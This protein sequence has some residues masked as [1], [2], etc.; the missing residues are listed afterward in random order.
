MQLRS[1]LA[2][3][4]VAS[5]ALAQLS[6]T[7]PN[8]YATAE[9]NS[10]N[11][12][13]WNRFTNTALRTQLL[14]D[15]TNFTNAGI[16]YPIVIS[17]LQWRANAGTT[18]WAGGVLANCTV[19]MSTA[20]VDQNTP[21]AT[22]ASNHGPNLATVYSGPVNFIAGTGAGTGIPGPTVV[23]LT[24]TPFVYDPN[25]GD[26]VIDCDI[27]VGAGSGT[28]TQLDVQTTASLSSRVYNSTVAGSP[29]GTIN[30]SHGVVVTL[31]YTPAAGL[32]PGFTA[33]GRDVAVGSTVQFTDQSFT[34]DPAGIL[35]RNWDLNGDGV[36]D[37]SATNPSFIY[38][39]EGRYNVSLQ[40][41][42]ALHGPVTVT[43]TNYLTVG[44][45]DASFTAQVQTGNLVIFTD[46]SAGQ[47]TSW[48]WDFQNDG[49]VDSTSQNAAFVYPSTGSYAVRLTVADAFSTDTVVINVGVGIIPV[50]NFGSTFTSATTTR[51][52]WFQ[53][54][55]KFSIVSLS[56][57]DESNHGL[58]NV[59]VYRMAAAPP[60]FS[61]SSS[62]GLEFF[63][64]GQPSN[65]P[66]PCAIS[67]D[68]GEFVGVLGACGDGTT[69]RSSY[70]T[71]AG[72]YAT[73]V[74]GAPTTLTRFLTQTNIVS[75]GGNAPYSTEVAGALGRV[76]MG[77]TSCVGIPYGTGTPSGAGPA[78]PVMKCT[79]LPFVGQTATL[80]IDQQDSNVLGFVAAGFGR[81]NQPTPFGTVLVNNPI[82]T[83]PLNGGAPIGPGTQTY[84]LAVPNNPALTG[85]GPI[86]WQNVNLIPATGTFS[87][88]NANEWILSN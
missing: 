27:P 88:S 34:S 14:Y 70:A 66:I 38:G 86:N 1:L 23:D 11:A 45:V 39:T 58:Q 78:A 40:C 44:A 61:A 80:V 69:M 63:S 65:A 76:F 30:T 29:T 47:P 83:A 4:L 56:V 33:S 32:Y 2:V 24:I 22:F 87:M 54:P 79:A 17:R 42:D 8:G 36:T 12:F 85:V 62:G 72:T 10:N 16:T 25:T 77:V 64:A 84:N 81:A 9:G 37:S 19:Q 75:T 13:P 67:F 50:P 15:S 5:S 3:A 74:L 26:L 52:L 35:V 57:P 71:P 43:R 55:T 31:D 28:G 53:S 41:I 59:A 48:Q 68:A 51:G 21:S 7:I 82:F 20:A 49:V 6:H 18:T 73:T 46:T 60:A